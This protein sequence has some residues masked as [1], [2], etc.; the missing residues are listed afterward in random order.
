MSL[1]FDITVIAPQLMDA[2]IYMD[3][4]PAYD[5]FREE[6]EAILD[7][8]NKNK[9]ISHHWTVDPADLTA[10][11]EDTLKN[12]QR[13]FL[14]WSYSETKDETGEKN[15]HSL[16]KLFFK[17]QA[18]T[19]IALNGGSSFI[20]FDRI[21][22]VIDLFKEK[23][24]SDSTVYESI[25]AFFKGY[26][27]GYFFNYLEERTIMKKYAEML[28]YLG[29]MSNIV[30]TSTSEKQKVLPKMAL[31]LPIDRFKYLNG[32][33]PFD[34]TLEII[35]DRIEFGTIT[36]EE[37]AD[38]IDD[39]SS[40]IRSNYQLEEEDG[41]ELVSDVV[42]S[43]FATAY[44]RYVNVH[45][46][47]DELY[48]NTFSG[49]RTFLDCDR[50]DTGDYSAAKI[51]SL[52]DD[53]LGKGYI[54]YYVSTREP[55]VDTALGGDFLGYNYPIIA[56]DE[57]CYYYAA[58]YSKYVYAYLDENIYTTE[59]VPA[60][61]FPFFDNALRTNAIRAAGNISDTTVTVRRDRLAV[62]EQIR[63]IQADNTPANIKKMLLLEQYM[64]LVSGNM[65]EAKYSSLITE[66]IFGSDLYEE[67]IRY[68]MNILVSNA[69]TG[70]DA[71]KVLLDEI[72][73]I[74]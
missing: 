51:N 29:V 73:K 62:L 1:K 8:F 67:Y 3:N 46:F 43:D 11:S 2:V 41:L 39:I 74:G 63:R 48:H 38:I 35:C 10:R 49:I 31:L 33:V 50:D 65:N 47:S 4:S 72:N 23:V 19:V 5:A 58:Y 71:K 21:Q 59:D 42:T 70:L 13:A 14:I 34:L 54:S 7:D 55:V 16:G 22:A 26:V 37:K 6:I 18:D 60:G 20:E 66:N 69:L 45:D 68:R 40:F 12:M 17:S 30:S 61:D 24:N 9:T 64:C 52:I 44:F 56:R 57:K 27:Y 15:V 53:K 36:E 32:F 28:A 25:K